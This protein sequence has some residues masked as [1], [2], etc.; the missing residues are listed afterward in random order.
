MMFRSFNSN[1]TDVT[2]LA[3]DANPSGAPELIPGY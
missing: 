3:G 1:T 2:S